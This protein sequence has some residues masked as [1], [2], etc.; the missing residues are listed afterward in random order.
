MNE[1]HHEDF[2]R[3][4]LNI[5]YYR[6]QKGITQ[7]KLAEMTSYSKNHIQKIETAM[8]SPSVEALLDIAEALEISPAKLFEIR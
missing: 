6:K 4:G 3:I 5:L 2:L 7:Q 1:R 8:A